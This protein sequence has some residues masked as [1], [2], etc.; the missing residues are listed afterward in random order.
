MRPRRGMV[1]E[2]F[3][4]SIL[5]FPGS[6][7]SSPFPTLNIQCCTQ[8][9]RTLPQALEGRESCQEALLS[10]S[11]GCYQRLPHAGS[12]ICV[13]TF[14]PLA[15]LSLPRR[16]DWGGQWRGGGK[17]REVD[18]YERPPSPSFVHPMLPRPMKGEENIFG[19]AHWQ[20]S[21][22][23]PTACWPSRD[24]TTFLG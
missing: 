2:P 23:G 22:I 15:S 12:E 9:S 21:Y 14:F 5:L 7:P 20:Q 8:Q 18:G 11:S 1:G 3:L 16:R 13:T 19:G 10:R 24:Y 17:G 4:L 6:P